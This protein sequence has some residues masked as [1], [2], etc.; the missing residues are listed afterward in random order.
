MTT[1]LGVPQISQTLLEDLDRVGRKY[2]RW[3]TEAYFELNGAY[4]VEYTNGRLEILPMPTMEHQVIL[5]RL[6]DAIRAAAEAGGRVLTA[7]ARVK[8][9]DDT[10]REPDVLYMSPA[11]RAF[12]HKEYT[13]RVSLVAEILSE[14]NRDHDL[15]TKRVEYADAGIP[16]YWIIDPKSRQ[17]S[18]L[19]LRGDSYAT[20]G[21]FGEGTTATSVVLGQFRVDVTKLFA[22]DD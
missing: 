6:Y 22:E 11:D 21:V 20:H 1:V 4:L 19:E 5:A 14:S 15:E 12:A 2:P 8:V 7:G 17:V 10:F 9:A 16:E 13:E 3:T 18:V